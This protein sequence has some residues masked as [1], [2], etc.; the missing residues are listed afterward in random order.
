M[1]QGHE[2]DYEVVY[3]CATDGEAQV[4]VG[5]LRNSG[6]EAFTN[7]SW[8]HTV[9]PVT[10]VGERES[11]IVARADAAKA[12]ELIADHPGDAAETA[13]EAEETP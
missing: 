6:V 3:E 2:M 1:E 12:R 9:Y 5:Y 10:S 7:S 11:V 4:I 13:F 8:P